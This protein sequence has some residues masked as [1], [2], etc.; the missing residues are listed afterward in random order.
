MKGTLEAVKYD[1]FYSA[2]QALL[3][4]ELDRLGMS[5]RIYLKI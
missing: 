5:R 4:P 1:P 2:K 3:Y